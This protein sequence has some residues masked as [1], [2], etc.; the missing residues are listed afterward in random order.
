MRIVMST[1][2]VIRRAR[3]ICRVFIDVTL[4]ILKIPKVTKEKMRMVCKTHERVR[5]PSSIVPHKQAIMC[6]CCEWEKKRM[7]ST[8][9]LPEIFI[10][11][12]DC[13]AVVRLRVKWLI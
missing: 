12:F 9:Y 1:T 11:L 8:F 2:R 3:Y 5:I 13:N 4:A 6:I 7:K 10:S